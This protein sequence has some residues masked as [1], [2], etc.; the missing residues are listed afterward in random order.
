MAL[1]CGNHAAGESVA[2]KNI[3]VTRQ[4]SDAFLNA[5]A[6][7]IVEADQRRAGAHGQIHD[8]ANF[9]GVSF[10]K[11]AAKN[12]EILR[13]NINQPAVDA[14]KAGNETVARWALLFHSKIDA[15]VADKFIQLLEGTFIEE[16][17][18]AFA[19]GEFAGFM[20]ALAAFR[21]SACFGFGG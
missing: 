17:I 10:G 16:Q 3:G 9:P 6:A 19:S 11:R 14:S 4:R 8:L 5:R 21:A 20:L 12:G 18:N 1:I 13:E 15:V 2:Q 7:G